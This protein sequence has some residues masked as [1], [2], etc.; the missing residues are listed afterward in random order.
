[1][2]TMLQGGNMK[3]RVIVCCAVLFLAMSGLAR[4]EDAGAETGSSTS[5]RFFSSQGSGTKLL[6]VFQ[7]YMQRDE[8]EIYYEL[9]RRKL[10]NKSYSTAILDTAWRMFCRNHWCYKRGEFLNRFQLREGQTSMHS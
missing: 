2:K 3:K 4:A 9:E 10:I 1:M 5:D 6:E 7:R 8:S